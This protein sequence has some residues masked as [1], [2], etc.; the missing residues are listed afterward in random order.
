MK[1]LTGGAVTNVNLCLYNLDG[2]ADQGARTPTMLQGYG[3][4]SEVSFID[5]FDG[6]MA[7]GCKDPE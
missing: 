7:K 2:L 3:N 5:N 1:V 4:H 6:E